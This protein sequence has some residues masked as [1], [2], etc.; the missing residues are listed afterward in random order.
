MDLDI[1]LVLTLL[2]MLVSVVSAAAIARH[3]I[4]SLIEAIKDIESRLRRLDTRQDKS[5]TATETIQQRLSVLSGMM[6]PSTM[7]RRH[8]EIERLKTVVEY[9]QKK[10][11]G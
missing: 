8:R 11:C 3:Q 4:K 9:L 6:D 10:V 7:E 2:G 1:R 5:E